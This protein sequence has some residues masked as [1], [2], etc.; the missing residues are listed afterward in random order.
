MRATSCSLRSGSGEHP[1]WLRGALANE[2]RLRWQAHEHLAVM[3]DIRVYRGGVIRTSVTFDNSK[4]F[5]PGFRHHLYDIAIGAKDAPAFFAENVAHHRASRWRRVFWTGGGA[6]AFAAQ[7]SRDLIAANAILPLDFSLELDAATVAQ[8]DA[9]L[10][11]PAPL[12]PAQVTQYFLQTGG[13]PDIG[14]YPDWTAHYLLAQTEPAARAMIAAAEAGCC[15]VAFH[16]RDD[17][18][19]GFN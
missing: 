19:A 2:Y 6:R 8:S 14:P 17:G 16:R 18:R 5:S 11:T 4:A 15:A 7:D 1:E 9:A 3:F 10:K 13:R 12:S